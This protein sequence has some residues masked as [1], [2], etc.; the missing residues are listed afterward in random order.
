MKFNFFIQ[1]SRYPN[2]L[3]YLG[4]AFVIGI[5]NHMISSAIWNK[6]A[7][8]IFQRLTN[9]TSPVRR[10]QF[11]V[12]E[13]FTSA[14]LFQIAREKSC[15][16]LLIIYVQKFQTNSR[17]F[18]FIL[19]CGVNMLRLQKPDW[20]KKWQQLVDM[21]AE[22]R[23]KISSEEKEQVLKSGFL[24]KCFSLLKARNRANSEKSRLACFKSSTFLH[25]YSIPKENQLEIAFV[26]DHRRPRHGFAYM[27]DS[28]FV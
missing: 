12:F 21:F 4:L 11:G 24:S 1:R 23:P 22:Y 16:Y 6:Y 3:I 8:V 26:N 18:V 5:G 10:V 27:Y 15:D 19:P 7:R 2:F 17:Q 28:V 13:N 20:S 9:C 25:F 14:Y